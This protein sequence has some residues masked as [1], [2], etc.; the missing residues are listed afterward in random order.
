MCRNMPE[1][2]YFGYILAN[3]SG[4]PYT[5]V[6]NDLERRI[7]EHKSKLSPSF[8]ARYNTTR[9]VYYEHTDDVWSALEREKQLKAG[10]D[11]RRS[12]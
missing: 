4:T 7:A 10:A 1:R 2:S 11:P 5:G 6:T 3:R 12:S 8:S 9:L